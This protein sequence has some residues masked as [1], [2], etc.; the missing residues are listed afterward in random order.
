MKN[1]K[2]KWM[3][4]SLVVLLAIVMAFA[5]FASLFFGTRTE[6]AAAAET[7][8]QTTTDTN[9][10][11]N[12]SAQKIEEEKIYSTATIDDDFSPDS[13][14]VILD[15]S[16]SNIY[17]LSTELTNQLFNGININSINDLSK[18]PNPSESLIEYYKNNTFKQT[19]HVK[20]NQSSKQNVLRVIKKLEQLDGVL[21]VGPDYITRVSVG[22]YNQGVSIANATSSSQWGLDDGFGSNAYEAW[23]T[24]KG[25]KNVRVGIIDSGIANHPDLNANLAKGWDF[26]ND[27]D[28]TNDDELGHGTHVAG[29]IGAN[30]RISGVAPNV[31][32]VPLQTS[33][34]VGDKIVFYC[35]DTVEA[36]QYA[37]SLW[38]TSNQ[39]SILNYSI[40]GFGKD[41]A[42]QEEIKKF[43]GLFV[44]TAGNRKED[45][46]EP[47]NVDTLPQINLFN[48]NNL[49]S[50]GAI[51][52]IGKRWIDSCYG[53]AVNIYAPG[54]D[55]LSTVL[56]NN[57]GR[58]SGTSMAAPHVSGVAALLLS[59][60][61]GLTGA[62]LKECI[63]KSAIPTVVD[64]T[65][66]AKNA[67]R[68]SASDA[69]TFAKNNYPPAYL[70]FEVVGNSNGWQVKLINESPFTVYATYNTKMCFKS[71]AENFTGL[72]DLEDKEIPGNSS[73]TVTIQGNGAARWIVATIN[74]SSNGKNYR[75][76]SYA[77]GLSKNGNIYSINTAKT[78]QI[79]VTLSYP[80][81]PS[82]PQNLII[83]PIGRDGTLIY[84]WE[85]IIFNENDFD[86]CVDFNLRMCFEG[87]AKTFNVNDIVKNMTVPAKG[88]IKTTIQSNGLADCVVA[89]IKY[90]Y[91][92][93]DY[94]LI[95]YIN[96][97]KKVSDTEYTLKT[98]NVNSIRAL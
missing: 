55:V 8:V 80:Q 26:V 44:W 50:V 79:S 91:R 40:G 23:E 89:R 62:N 4:R 92:G 64:N 45:Q 58:W 28:I 84:N 6:T 46:T 75:K 49:I 73:V 9:I 95:T 82:H 65:D 19:L 22:D 59:I 60:E 36:I 47:I 1:I 48:L 39:I 43:P 87:D 16:K 13:V 96:K 83:A 56:N 29:I 74:Y 18:I 52:N 51:N 98:T 2:A 3:N 77:N 11:A 17:G 41:V 27:N 68:L 53:N 30:G 61:P 20:L 32:L 35:S 90:S 85:V 15:K 10:S 37:I 34:W 78:K 86:V 69:L 7:P 63:L 14:I 21:Y 72:S 12:D 54:E 57:Y 81:E 71:D 97:L 33:A 76:I 24:T 31:T 66:S 94:Q 70:D 5:A 25:S 42:I 88:Y 93:F 38:G 67:V